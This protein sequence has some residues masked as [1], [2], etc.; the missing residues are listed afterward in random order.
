MPRCTPVGREEGELVDMAV[1]VA[2]TVGGAGA[3]VV[4][5]TS[6]VSGVGEDVEP[7][8]GIGG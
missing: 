1:A 4:N 2:A 5:I 6:P 7:E 3:V 8:A